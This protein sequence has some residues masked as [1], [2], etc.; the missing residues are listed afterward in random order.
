M[1]EVLSWMIIA[2]TR[3]VQDEGW[4]GGNVLGSYHLKLKTLLFKEL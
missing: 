4:G 3:D 1:E 2:S